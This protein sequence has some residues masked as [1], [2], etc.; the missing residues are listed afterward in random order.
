M[1]RKDPT[2]AELRILRVLWDNG[3]SRL[4]DV[5][6]ELALEKDV[7]ATTVATILKIMEEKGF[8]EKRE[9]GTQKLWAARA[10]Q[11]STARGLVRGVMRRMFDGSPRKLMAHLI[12]SERLSEA[13]R[14]ELLE[15]LKR[16][17]A[18]K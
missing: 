15:L 5:R 6:R 13:D 8:V 11:R 3:P 10:S 4:S 12:E 14:R 1:S 16:R 18:K 9:T 2:E 17:P 7:A